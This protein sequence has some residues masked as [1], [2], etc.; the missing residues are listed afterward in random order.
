MVNGWNEAYYDEFSA[1][2]KGKRPLVVS[3]ATSPAAEVFFA[4][5]PK[6]AEP[7]TGNILPAKGSFRQVEFVGILKGAKEPELARKFVDFMLGKAFQEDVPLQMF[8]YPANAKA[9]IPGR[10]HQVRAGARP[11]RRRGSQD[12]RGEARRLDPAMDADRPQVA[13]PP[14]VWRASP[15]PAPARRSWRAWRPGASVLFVV[16]FLLYPLASILA[17]GLGP[18][19]GRRLAG[20]LLALVEQTGP[21]GARWP[22]PP[23]RR[24]S[25]P[26]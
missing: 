5:D 26:C 24:C 11:A 15:T 14:P 23:A 8:V 25:P 6:P 19:G 21:G 16:L 20:G 10:L 12:H 18:A 22:S 1:A 13:G 4:A 2:G 7:P 17:L 9:S 3:Y